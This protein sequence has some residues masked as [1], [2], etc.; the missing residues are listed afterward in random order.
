MSL[1]RTT[2]KVKL[3]ENGQIL[4][5]KYSEEIIQYMQRIPEKVLIPP[6]SQKGLFSILWQAGIFTLGCFYSDQLPLGK[7]MSMY[8]SVTDAQVF[9]RELSVEEM[10]DIT[11]CRS[12]MVNT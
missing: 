2:G 6:H 7:F 10:V 9:S 12:V 5:D 1:S 4:D 11:S 3:I 8:E